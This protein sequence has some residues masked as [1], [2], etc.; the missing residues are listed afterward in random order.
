[1]RKKTALISLTTLLFFVIT[2]QCLADVPDQL[3]QAETLIKNG[4]YGQAEQIYL[5]I[6][7]DYPG[8]DHALKAQKKLAM[9]Y[10]NTGE[11]S[12]AEIA[13][14]QLIANF[15]QNPGVAKAVWQIAQTYK[16]AREYQKAIELYRYVVNNWPG[17]IIALSAQSS[18]AISFELSSDKAAADAAY[19]R[20]L[21]VLPDY[22]VTA[23]DVY[24]IAK[25]FNWANLAAKASGVHQYN[26]EH[27]PGEK[28]ALWSQVEVIFHHIRSG[29]ESAS[30]TEVDRFL[31][32]FAG[33]PALP[34]DVYNVA[35]EYDKAGRHRKA[36]ELYQYVIEHRPAD[37]D[38][39]ARMSA[40]MAY[41]GLGDDANAL[42]VTDGLIF[43]FYDHSDLAGV[44]FHIGE[45]YYEKAFRAENEALETQAK[46]NFEKALTVW[47]KI[48]TDLPVS[49]PN[50]PKAYYFSAVCYRRQGE[51]EVA[52]EYYSIVLDN[53]PNY[54][55]AW[56]A[57]FRIARC[58]EKLASSGRIPKTEAA[59][60]ICQACEKLLAN[61]PESKG[62]KPALDLL[63]YWDSINSK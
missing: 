58:Y 27:F 18:L 36:L 28:H 7:K 10:I 44:V 62:V 33:H 30:D 4:Q 56:V 45:Q 41:I 23:E 9:L 47:E 16:K 55:Y 39:Y 11:D 17:D 50:T 2:G 63:E 60:Q 37:E 46:E 20:L 8:S 34:R 15:S 31:S 42:A 14:Q 32:I 19:E 38:I 57:Q 43:D 49:D 40:S 21:Q 5:Q 22:E 61:Y 26:V 1:M 29:D 48:I 24:W 54:E 59:A 6:L 3:E 13:Y 53:W 25:T 12:Q 52:I 35:K 51:Y